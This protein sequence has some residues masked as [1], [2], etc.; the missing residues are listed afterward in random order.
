MRFV[1][2]VLLAMMSYRTFFPFHVHSSVCDKE[3]NS[4]DSMIALSTTAL[5]YAC[6]L[7]AGHGFF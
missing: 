5:A 4:L 6:F 7:P 2:Q 1:V 3:F